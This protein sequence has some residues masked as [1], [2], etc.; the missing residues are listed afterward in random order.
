MI[1]LIGSKIVME[2][3]N[4]AVNEIRSDLDSWNTTPDTSLHVRSTYYG[5]LIIF[6]T[7]CDYVFT[8]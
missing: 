7:Y 6:M 3:A 2:T 4:P 8:E 5:N 1:V